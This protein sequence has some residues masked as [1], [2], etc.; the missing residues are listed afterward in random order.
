MNLKERIKEILKLFG[1]KAV[2]VGRIAIYIHLG[3]L[4]YMTKD[5]DVN[6]LPETNIKKLLREIEK[7]GFSV[8]YETETVDE[9]V[10]KL[11]AGLVVKIY[12]D[13]LPIDACMR[14]V[15]FK[16]AMLDDIKVRVVDERELI[17]SRF[18]GLCG[19]NPDDTWLVDLVYLRRKYPNKWRAEYESLSLDEKK[20][21]KNLIA[22]FIYSWEDVKSNI[23]KKYRDEVVNMIKQLGELI[24]NDIEKMTKREMQRR[25]VE[26]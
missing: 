19:K 4:Y 21:I 12:V 18:K 15:P 3:E 1:D 2:I 17:R 20:A 8:E 25:K 11:E 5:L 14:D 16:E 9:L 24:Q 10:K 26:Q 6:F 13:G 23:P 22:K 7:K